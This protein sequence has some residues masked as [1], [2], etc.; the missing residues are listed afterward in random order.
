MVGKSFIRVVRTYLCFATYSVLTTDRWTALVADT[1]ILGFI[2]SGR[3]CIGYRV[4]TAMWTGTNMQ[5]T[6][7]SDV[8]LVPLVVYNYYTMST[9]DNRLTMYCQR[10]LITA[11]S[12]IACGI[13]SIAN[14]AVHFNDDIAGTSEAR[15]HT[16]IHFVCET[17]ILRVFI[18]C[19][20]FAIC[21]PSTQRA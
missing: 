7:D 2:L 16:A 4:P 10:Y 5:P 18:V 15:E 1:F 6:P 14:Y 17:Y 8:V 11:T 3:C 19:S 13:L 21:Q 12:D 20:L 9:A